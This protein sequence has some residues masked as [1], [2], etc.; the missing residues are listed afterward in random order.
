MVF[1]RCLESA[2]GAYF[3]EEDCEA[4]FFREWAVHRDEAFEYKKGETWDRL[5]HQGIH[6]LQRFAQDNRVRVSDP[7][8]SLQ[9]KQ[10]RLLPN[11]SE[12]VAYFDA[13]GEVD[14][15]RCLIDWKTITSRYSEA[16]EGLLSLDPQ[17]IC[18]S[19]MSGIAEVGMAVFVRKHAAEVQYLRATISE[20]QRQEFGRLVE[21]TVGQ[22]EAGYFDS[23]SGIAEFAFPR[24]DVSAAHT[25]ASVSRMNNSQSPTWSVSQGQ[26]AWIGS[27]SLWIS[28]GLWCRRNSTTDGPSL[29]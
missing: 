10:L 14:G 9:V 5:L 29:S 11:G 3:R 17:L 25:W 26:V 12:F 21:T 13:L 4:A 19:W 8:Q 16:P 6:L 15:V 20:E 28:G 2:L 27:M 23:H 22:I 1:G 7:S 24:T 18:C